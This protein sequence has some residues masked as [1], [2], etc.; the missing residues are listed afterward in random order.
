MKASVSFKTTSHSATNSPLRPMFFST[1]SILVAAVVAFSP[2]DLIAPSF[3]ILDSNNKPCDYTNLA[4]TLLPVLVG[5]QNC[6]AVSNYTFLPPSG[7]PTA[8][9]MRALCSQPMCTAALSSLQSLS[10][11]NCTVNVNNRAEPLGSMVSDMVAQCTPPPRTSNPSSLTSLPLTLAPGKNAS[12]QLQ[13][14]H[15]AYTS[16][17][18]AAVLLAAIAI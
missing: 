7:F 13:R 2:E 10:L 3:N 16:V 4:P 14:S 15:A 18:V 5:L 17:A 8:A 1:L 9:Q 11:P 12:K 6:T